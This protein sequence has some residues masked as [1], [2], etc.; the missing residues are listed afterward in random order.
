[1]RRLVLTLAFMALFLAAAAAQ[2]LKV[3]GVYTPARVEPGSKHTGKIRLNQPA[4]T[5][6]KVII[7]P[8]HVLKLPDTVIIPEGSVEEEFEIEVLKFTHRGL[9]FTPDTSISTLFKGKIE[10]WPGPEIAP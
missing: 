7:F 6:V 1:M 8:T 9:R 5:E 3:E 2:P 4:P 10:E